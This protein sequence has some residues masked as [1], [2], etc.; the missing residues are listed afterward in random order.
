[1]FDRVFPGKASI[2]RGLT[3]TVDRG[4][5][6]T[7]SS[8]LIR[9]AF[10]GGKSSRIDLGGIGRPVVGTLAPPDG[11]PEDVHWNF[12]SVDVRP[13]IENEEEA[14]P[15]YF[16]ASVDRTG[17]FRIEDVPAGKY[18]LSVRFHKFPAGHLPTQQV[19]VPAFEG[20]F[21]EEPLD[22]GTLK[23]ERN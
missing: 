18:V 6:E 17:R 14:D 10:P 5:T 20:K 11:F 8:C 15:L 2:G 23:L 3:H 22:L 16:H 1:V 13:L 12:A 4:A 9:A 7:A 19:V 21:T